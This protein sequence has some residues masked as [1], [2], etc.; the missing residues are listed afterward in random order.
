MVYGSIIRL[1]RTVAEEWMKIPLWVFSVC[2]NRED[3]KETMMPK[4]IRSHDK[5]IQSDNGSINSTQA[6]ANRNTQSAHR[7]SESAL[8]SI[9]NKPTAFLHFPTLQEIIQTKLVSLQFLSR[10]N[11]FPK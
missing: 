5:H 10:P 2:M 6:A 8:N 7:T 9:Q 3:T 1:I 4:N 11:R